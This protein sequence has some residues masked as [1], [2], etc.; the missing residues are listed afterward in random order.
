M[1]CYGGVRHWK[2]DVSVS[3]SVLISGVHTGIREN[4]TSNFQSNRWK[5]DADYD[6]F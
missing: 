1:G 3:L 6:F 5:R 4:F 2:I